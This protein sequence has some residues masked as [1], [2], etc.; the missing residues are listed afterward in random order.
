MIRKI[1]S[2]YGPCLSSTLV[3]LIVEQSGISQEAARKRVSRG[4]ANIKKLSHL[5]FQRKVRFIYL[6]EQYAS[7]IYWD[8]LYQAIYESGGA[9]ARALCAVTE[10]LILTIDQFKIACGSPI[11]Q[12]KHISADF[13]LDRLVSANVLVK[14]YL[15]DV[16]DCVMTKP[17]YEILHKGNDVLVTNVRGRLAAESVLIDSVKEWLRRLAFAS[18]NSVKVRSNSD[19]FPM[20]GTFGWDITAPSYISGLTSWS[21]SEVKP[22]FVVCD[23]L[24]NCEVSIHTIKPFLY[25]V[26]TTK[27]LRNISRVMFVFVA[28]KYTP[29]A[30]LALREVGVIP[31][32]TQSLFGKDVAHGFK[33]LFSV[34]KDALEGDFN[35][36][37]FNKLFKYLRNLDGAIGNMRGTFFEYLVA[38]LIRKDAPTE[39]EI[40]K[41][42][43]C[44][45]GKA[46]VDVWLIKSNVI[47]RFIEC[48]GVGKGI[49]VN[50]PDIDLWLDTRILRVRQYLNEHLNWKGPKPIFELWT[51]GEISEK[52]LGR[53]EKV[54]N[55]NAKKFDVVVV[56]PR[57]IRAQLRK[58]KDSE[59]TNAFK[60]YL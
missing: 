16:G 57:K 12:K 2:D 42:F 32:T 4:G 31:A 21:G 6:Q 51:S 27:A 37:N 34:F 38:E 49:N 30:F 48:K 23:V 53:I 56:G 13:V 3:E 1:L 5:P 29:E 28:E 19:F 33:S 40:N 58:F 25:K 8:K 50:D 44:S 9:Y 11:A 26:S 45:D 18:F 35:L 55:A 47:A 36:N 52:S 41:K 22:G 10:R 43:S 14:S 15:P 46:E 39:I 59:L 17:V 20:V 60:H 54:R 7:P 24:L